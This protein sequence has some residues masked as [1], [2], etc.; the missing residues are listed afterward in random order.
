[1][2]TSATIGVIQN[3]DILYTR[4]NYDGDFDVVGRNLL[5]YFSDYEAAKDLVN[6]G[7]IRGLGKY[8]EP[9]PDEL[10]EEPRYDENWIKWVRA[11]GDYTEFYHRDKDEDWDDVKPRL[12][13]GSVQDF[14][15]SDMEF[16]TYYHDGDEWYGNGS[17]VSEYGLLAK[18][19][20]DE[21]DG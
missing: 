8:I 2:G 10:K 6:H 1:M 20:K 21:D 12:Y 14:M 13:Q 7:E 9:L 3:D 4:V 19:I 18:I 11:K 5:N 15:N 16:Y 17:E